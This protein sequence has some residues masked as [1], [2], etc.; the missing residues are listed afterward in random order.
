MSHLWGIQLIKISNC[1]V[2]A[3]YIFAYKLNQMLTHF[4]GTSIQT[5]FASR[6]FDID[7]IKKNYGLISNAI[8]LQAQILAHTNRKNLAY[9]VINQYLRI[10]C[11]DKHCSRFILDALMSAADDNYCSYYHGSHNQKI[12]QIVFATITSKRPS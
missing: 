7:L 4:V 5:V 10:L 11:G 1:M 9:S 3:I 8:I 6:K 12:V 2:C